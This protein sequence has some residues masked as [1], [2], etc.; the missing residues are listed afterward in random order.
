[1]LISINLLSGRLAICWVVHTLYTLGGDSSPSSLSEE[2]SWSGGLRSAVD[3]DDG[4]TPATSILMQTRTP[5]SDVPLA[6]PKSQ[7]VFLM[8]ELPGVSHA[9]RKS[10]MKN[11]R[12]E[13][14]STSVGW[15]WKEDATSLK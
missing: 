8:R 10:K 13:P 6:S 1:M 12:G 2:R 9:N 5:A 7:Q 4:K 11:G 14:G 3:L 15:S